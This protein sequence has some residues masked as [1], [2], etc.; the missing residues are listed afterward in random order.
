M[1]VR[2]GVIAAL[3]VGTSKVTCFIARR[4]A[5]DS[6]R[7]IGVGTHVSRGMRAG[8]VV[9]MEETERAIRAA[10]ES[11]ERMAE[12]TVREVYLNVSGTQPTSQLLSAEITLGGQ[13][14]TGSDLRRV[15]EQSL[16]R[17]DLP[18]REV[19]HAIPLGYAVDGNR[20][21]RDPLGMFCAHLGVDLHAVTV[22]AGPLRNLAMCVERGHL[23]I[24]D[25]AASP[26]ASGLGVL[27]SDEKE[28][29]VTLIDM[30]AGITSL[31]VF[32]SG[33]PVYTDF[34]PLGGGH[35]THDVARGLS[36]P[37]EYAERL[38]TLYGSALPS[39]SDE[40]E[41]LRVPQ[42]GESEHESTTEV[43]CSVLV[44]IIQPRIEET[45]EHVRARLEASG[46]D[47]L[48]G[49]RV[50]L[51]G[52]ACQLQG[53]RELAA[54]ILDK[55]VRIGRPIK[56]GGLSDATSGPAFATCAGLLAYGQA[57]EVEAR[58]WRLEE[59]EAPRG[60]LAKVGRW[61]HAHL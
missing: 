40:R 31:A 52:G 12:E 39:P 15:R 28:L 58:T 13:P 16:S 55:Q 10:V 23:A 19:V 54:R 18:G 20:G 11:A 49:R 17:L 33:H 9:D 38:K 14:I 1:A 41:I 35:I 2:G 50:V 32:V 59:G 21:V 60:R 57:G 45:F 53:V 56:L 43:P 24:A 44:G 47:R 48:S 46:F 27:V 34:V 4:E 61:L 42:V 22:P 30:G 8:T 37:A 26:Y 6:R 51:T 36:T 3:D 5:D 29:G 7:V 25:V